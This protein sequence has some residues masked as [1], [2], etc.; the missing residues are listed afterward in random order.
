MLHREQLKKY[1]ELAVRVGVNLQPGQHLVIGF[2]TRQVLPDHIE[3]ARCL[4]EAGYDAGA[5]FVQIDWGDEWWLRET[6]RRGSLDTLAARAQWQNQWVERLAEEGAAFIAIPAADPELFQG[7]DPDRVRQALQSIAMAFREFNDKRTNDEYTWTLVSA[8]TKPWADKVMAHLPESERVEALWQAILKAARADGADPVSDWKVHLGNLR[9][10]ADWINGLGI[11]KL[12]YHAPG[13]DLTV[14]MPDGHFWSAAGHNSA[15][16]VPFVANIPTEEVYATPHK[17]GVN[18][19]VRSTMPLNHNGTLIEGIELR[20]E[21]GRIVEYRAQTGQEALSSIIETDE[22][23][24]YLG[25]VA[26][27]PVDS[28]ISQM[29][30][31]FYNTLFDENASCHLAIGR[32][33]PL[34][35]GGNKLPRDQWDARGLND[36]L[37]HVDF[38][39]GSE[40]LDI[41]AETKD[42]QIVP[43]FRKGRWV[44][45]V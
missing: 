14:E 20:F 10:R 18:G 2:A 34:I 9:K 16:G 37:M 15:Q 40:E 30:L 42:G 8:P 29:G 38:M 26:L 33:Y 11:R 22:G 23:S 12:H 19:T 6:I 21:K 43:I 7:V 3:F 27:V 28:P 44:T 39:I 1:A 13:T 36:S 25:E 32:A 45:Q 41:D 5:K 17:Y 31:L 24:H 4:T 35:E